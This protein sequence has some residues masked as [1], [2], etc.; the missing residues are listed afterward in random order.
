MVYKTIITIS[1][2]VLSLFSYSQKADSINIAKAQNV[3]RKYFG[4]SG[5]VNNCLLYGID[6]KYIFIEKVESSF[7]LF[8]VS[9]LNGIED[10]TSFKKRHK[11]LKRAFNPAACQNQFLYTNSDTINRYQHPH[12][13]FI[14]FMLR[15]NDLKVCEFNLPAMFSID[16]RKKIIYPLDD[17]VQAFLVK[18]YS[19]QWK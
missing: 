6:N 4:S 5:R 16:V 13:R 1:F 3:L 19:T 18:K 14:Y 8:Y 15:R 10:S 11:I 12:S 9:E 7:K 2:F 17:R